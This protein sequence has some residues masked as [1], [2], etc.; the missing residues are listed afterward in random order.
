[1]FMMLRLRLLSTALSL[2][3]LP[4]AAEEMAQRMKCEQV[5]LSSSLATTTQLP[6]FRFCS[7]V[8]GMQQ[9]SD[10]ETQS[11]H[12]LLDDVVTQNPSVQSYALQVKSSEYGLKSANGAWWPNVSMSNSSVLFTDILSSQNYGGSPAT[13]SS[14]ATSG[15]AFNP[16][17]GSTPRDRFRGRSNEIGRAHV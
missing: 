5:P 12:S 6:Q 13:P 8:S 1:M 11:A 15:T 7:P 3:P 4:V 16:F 14:P 17:N 9:S 2:L 10:L